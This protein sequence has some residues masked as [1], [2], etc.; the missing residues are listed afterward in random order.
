MSTPTEKV[1][2]LME[3]LRDRRPQ[4]K[5]VEVKSFGTVWLRK[6]TGQDQMEISELKFGIT[7]QGIASIPNSVFGACL[8]VVLFRNEDGSRMFPDAKAAFDEIIQSDSDDLVGI[9]NVVMEETGIN[10]KAKQLLEDAEKKSSSG[11]KSDSGT[12]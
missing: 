5:A 1:A 4:L 10:A 7:R 3:R 9:Y 11:Q 6:P 2:T 8:A 12:N